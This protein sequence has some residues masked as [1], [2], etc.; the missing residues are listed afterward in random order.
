MSCV[1]KKPTGICCWASVKNVTWQEQ[2]RLDLEL[3]LIVAAMVKL[4]NFS[5]MTA[6]LVA[7]RVPQ[8]PN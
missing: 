7:F 8:G 6:I 5:D 2:Q 1:Q 3:W 4:A